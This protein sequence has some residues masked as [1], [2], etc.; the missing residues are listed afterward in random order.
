MLRTVW[1]TENE[2]PYGRRP[3]VLP[4]PGLGLDG[5]GR[6]QPCPHPRLVARRGAHF[7]SGFGVQPEGTSVPGPMPLHPDPVPTADPPHAPPAAGRHVGHR[8]TQ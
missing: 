2:S 3:P 8:Q 1:M 5:Q 7:R 4:H 6:S